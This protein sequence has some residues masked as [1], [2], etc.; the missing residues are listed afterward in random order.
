[1]ITVLGL[2]VVGLTTALG[3]SEKGFKVFGFEEDLERKNELKAGRLPFDEPNLLKYLKKH[4]NRNFIISDDLHGALVKSD[5]VMFCVGTPSRDSGEVDLGPLIRVINA[6]LLVI[7]DDKFRVICIKSTVPPSTTQNDIAELLRKSGREPGIDI[8]LAN[9]P[10]FLREGHAWDDFNEPDRIIIG[11][12]DKKSRVILSR[13]YEPF[14]V[15]VHYVNLNTA[16]YIKYLSNTLL[17]SLISYANELSMIA[18]EI[19][20]IDIMKAFHILHGDRRWSGLPAQM[21]TYV[22]PGCG[23]GGYCLPKDTAALVLKADEIGLDTPFLKSVLLI[24][25][26]IGEFLIDRVMKHIEHDS[27]IAL[28]GLSFKPHSNDVRTSPSAWIIE[29]LKGKGITNIIAY[30]PV[31]MES[32]S[33]HYDYGIHFAENM[34]DAIKEADAVI[35]VTAWP[36]FKL[37]KELLQD[38]LFFDFR[39][40]I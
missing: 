16:E 34:Q 17:A 15:N 30:D 13:Y 26:K 37:K 9:N 31:S 3:F 8:G 10:E 20:D 25:K 21:S 14:N 5:L 38:K 18:H 40:Y 35:I 39:Y 22:H 33:N 4:L 27:C 6:V 23:F 1:M 2:G 36:E 12:I 29:E 19:G 24:N 11:I 7:K 32:F 28:L